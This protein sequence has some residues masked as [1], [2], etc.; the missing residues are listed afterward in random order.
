MNV[1]QLAQGVIPAAAVVATWFSAPAIAADLHEHLRTREQAPA[2]CQPL[3]GYHP[4]CWR[5]FPA[6]PACPGEAS[7]PTCPSSAADVPFARET[8]T[9]GVSTWRRDSEEL[10][11]QAD[12]AAGWQPTPGHSVRQFSSDGSSDGP[13]IHVL[14]NGGDPAAVIDTPSPP[15]PQTSPLQ[16]AP[17]GTQS[18]PMLPDLPELP[19][20]LPQ[21]SEQTPDPRGALLPS[22]FPSQSRYPMT[23]PT[24]PGAGWSQQSSSSRYAPVNGPSHSHAVVPRTTEPQSLPQQTTLQPPEPAFSPGGW[25]TSGGSRYGA[26]PQPAIGQQPV[27]VQSVG[28]SSR[29]A[30]PFPRPRY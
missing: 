25:P 26:A 30:A 13:P 8:V 1:R 19:A 17:S 21:P 9:G 16:D 4:T 12:P 20:P 27:P 14:P 29:S 11:P 23:R 7:C 10:V 3:W 2:V 6:V 5:R 18:S 15:I 28:Q 22:P 24:V